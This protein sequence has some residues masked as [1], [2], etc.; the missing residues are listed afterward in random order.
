MVKDYSSR[1]LSDSRDK[2]PALWGIAAYFA[3]A[4][5][6]DYLAGLWRNIPLTIY[7]G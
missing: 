5:E 7:L 2:L 6:D 4:M 1:H 3:R